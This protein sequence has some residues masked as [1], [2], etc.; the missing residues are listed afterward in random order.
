MIEMRNNGLIWTPETI[1]AFISKPEGYIP[2]NRMRME[3][4]KDTQTR[5]F[6]FSIT[7]NGNRKERRKKWLLNLKLKSIFNP[8]LG[9]EMHGLGKQ[10]DLNSEKEAIVTSTDK[11]WG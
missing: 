4:I 10:G 9:T 5:E 6:K 8:I 1:N 7:S 3:G 11:Y 2:G